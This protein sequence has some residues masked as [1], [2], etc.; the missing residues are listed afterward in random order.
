MFTN[1]GA[2]GRFGPTQ[3]QVDNS[4]GPGL[5]TAINGIQ[6]WVVAENGNYR[7]EAKGASAVSQTLYSDYSD[8]IGRG[9]RMAGDF[10]LSAGDTIRVLVGQ[11]PTQSEFNGGG[12][13]SFVVLFSQNTNEPLIV[14]GGGGSYRCGYDF[15]GDW[16]TM[17]DGSVDE[18]G[19]DSYYPGG[20][21]GLG[22][23]A[24]NGDSGGGG[25]GF[26]SNGSECVGQAP[27]SFVEGGFG[28]FFDPN[29]GYG[30][31]DGGFG[32]GG[33]GGWGGSG[34][35]GGWSGGGAP[36]NNPFPP[37]GGG[38]SF[39]SGLNQSNEPGANEGHGK[40]TIV[41]ISD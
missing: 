29:N 1:C 35:G 24:C 25:A 8:R 14:A 20:Q 15:A 7:I 32:G 40:V 36:Y 27:S 37:A 6:Q 23:T 9:A 3:A 33:H 39:N 18:N 38:G 4:Y 12:G 13:G 22:A 2:E 11:M 19:N 41:R 34:G 28:G 21:N 17:L 26:Y 30:S 10:N 16:Q 5:I 31:Q